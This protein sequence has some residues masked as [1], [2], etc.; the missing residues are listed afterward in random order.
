M[1]F[2]IAAATVVS[3]VGL[4]ANGQS[5]EQAIGRKEIEHELR[6]EIE[7]LKRKLQRAKRAN[8]H[9][10]K[11]LT[12]PDAYYQ[13]TAGLA[14]Y[15]SPLNEDICQNEL[16]TMNISTKFG[17]DQL[18]K[19]NYTAPNS[20]I[21]WRY[22]HYNGDS[23]YGSLLR[24]AVTQMQES[25]DD[26]KKG[27][28]LR[29]L[30]NHVTPAIMFDVDNTVQ[31]TGRSDTDPYGR[32]PPIPEVVN[33]LKKN[34]ANF[35][36]HNTHGVVCYAISA[37]YCTKMKVESGETFFRKTFGVGKSYFDNYLYY[38]GALS[39]CKTT[40]ED[41]HIAYKDVLRAA[42]QRKH[43]VQFVMSL[44]DQ[45]TDSVG[46]HS[47]IKVVLPNLLFQSNIFGNQFS[48][49]TLPPN[50]VAPERLYSI[51]VENQTSFCSR[52]S[53][54]GPP[55]TCGPVANDDWVIKLASMKFCRTQTRDVV[56]N[57]ETGS[58]TYNVNAKDD[59]NATSCF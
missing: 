9:L 43:K 4:S 23:A 39:G 29:N 59:L 2:F 24:K 21:V 46:K 6:K 36:G 32:A 55:E 15:I 8:L 20:D 34:C 5:S 18:I 11:K 30:P 3:L 17:V 50:Y 52:R 51:P 41:E 7:R 48:E 58:C 53:I 44:G 57:Q 22:E 54:I 27:G 47:G 40:V 56:P 1:K 38:S 13:E 31:F 10:F 19:E 33:F 42:L 28:F 35:G 25:L 16:R 49:N 12:A 14:K 26:L 45:K 37:R